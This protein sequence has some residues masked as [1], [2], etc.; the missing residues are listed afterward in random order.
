ME[1]DRCIIAVLYESGMRIGE[2]MA[3]RVGMVEL[4]EQRQDVTFHIPNMKGKGTKTG[5]RPVVCLE[6]YNYVVDWLKC[7]PKPAP[8]EKFISISQSGV[9][10]QVRR[11]FQRAK[12]GKPA[13]LHNFRHSAI[14][15]ACILQ[16]QPYDISMRFWG[17]PNSNMFSVYIHLS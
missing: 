2:L 14:T 5:A 9:D 16:M 15:N 17:I 8:A 1:R 11:I 12:I 3:L 6:V 4:N 7:H 10:K 13:N